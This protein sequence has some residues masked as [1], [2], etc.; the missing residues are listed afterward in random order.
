MLCPTFCD[1]VA[2]STEGK[3]SILAGCQSGDECVPTSDFENICDDGIDNDC[4]G[5]VD[6]EEL[7]C[8]Q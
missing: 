6:R 8:L 1:E 3:L 2:A 7:E 5:A 4:D